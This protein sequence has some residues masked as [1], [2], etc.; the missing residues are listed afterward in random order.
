MRAIA[1]PWALAYRPLRVGGLLAQLAVLV[2]AELSLWSS[3]SGHEARFHWATHFLVGLSVAAVVNL[4]W[5]ALKGAPARGQ[6][7]SVLGWHLV[8]MF[9]DLLFSAG[10]AHQ[11][12]MNVFL[13]HI[14]AHH[15]PGATYTWLGIALAASA[16]YATVLSGW[17]AARRAEADA[18]LAPGVGIGGGALIRPQFSTRARTL[19]HVR[20]GPPGPPD[21]MLLHGLAA[22]SELWL[23]VGRRLAD[24]GSRV[25]IPDLLGFG[26]SRTIGTRFML[27]D[28]VEALLDLL[29]DCDATQ[30]RVVGHSFGCAVAVALARRAPTR[31]TRTV[32]VCPPTF[33]DGAQ[34]RERL[35]HEGWLARRVLRGS[36]VASATCGAMCLLRGPA[37]A[38]TRRRLTDIP[39]EVA[40]DSVQ[41]SWPAYRD[42]LAT[43]LAENPIPSWISA[44]GGPTRIVLADAD[45]RTP[46]G[47]VLDHPHDLVDVVVLAGDHLLPLRRP[48]VVQDVILTAPIS[49]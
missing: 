7:L 26:G 21:V 20:L 10:I 49:L 2:V 38:V 3:Y 42:A 31:V 36:P 25:L 16:I 22:S 43:M 29:D 35:G 28:H 37:A 39:A 11:G 27:D 34:A 32:L 12:W 15:I 40:R 6:L 8:A 23:P 41:H 13:G 24:T 46:A 47:D 4:G 17:L 18:G 30:V 48:D 45:L 1:E 19:A 33:R 9:P 44:P 14:A 5:L